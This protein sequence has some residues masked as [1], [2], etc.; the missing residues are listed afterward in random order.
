MSSAARFAFVFAVASFLS[1]P[2]MVIAAPAKPSFEWHVTHAFSMFDWLGLS[3]LQ[4]HRWTPQPA[5]A[6]HAIEN[7]YVQTMSPGSDTGFGKERLPKRGEPAANYESSPYGQFVLHLISSGEPKTWA[8]PPHRFPYHDGQYERAYAQPSSTNLTFKLSGFS[9]LCRLA[10]SDESGTYGGPCEK[11]AILI[12]VTLD[13]GKRFTHRRV[14]V[15]DDHGHSLTSEIQIEHLTIVGLGDSYAAG[16]GDP[17]APTEWS[18][19]YRTMRRQDL[20]NMFEKGTWKWIFQ[21]QKLD[22]ALVRRSAIWEDNQC[23]RSFWSHQ[24]MVAL[25]LASDSSHRLVTFLHYACTGA[26]VFDGL[27]VRQNVP[28]G[29]PANC[30]QSGHDEKCRVRR[31]QLAAAVTDL[32]Q[33]NPMSSSEPSVVPD[34]S[35]E[36]ASLQELLRMHGARPDLS[37]LESYELAKR[38]DGH[39]LDLV[40]CAG[41]LI[42]PDLVMLS[43]G[44]NDIGFGPLV[45]W[46]LIPASSY[47]HFG[48][49]FDRTWRFL[50]RDPN[51]YCPRV[52][53]STLD[54]KPCAKY[55][56]SYFGTLPLRLAVLKHAL[57][58]FMDVTPQSVVQPNYPD[59]FRRS[60]SARLKDPY[61]PDQAGFCQEKGMVINHGNGWDGLRGLVA[62]LS[63]STLDLRN[64]QINITPAE[65]GFAYSTL[66]RFR[67]TLRTAAEGAQ[68][69]S[70]FNFIDEA[71]DA[72]VGHGFCEHDDDANA[73]AGAPISLPSTP[74]SQRAPDWA[75]DTP[76][77]CAIRLDC[78]HPFVPMHRSVRTV[79]DSIRTQT[80][81][82]GDQLAGAFHPTAQGQAQIADLILPAARRVVETSTGD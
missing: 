5:K 23:N 67:D 53:G 73:M 66:E 24:N 34:Y 71:K 2:V 70:A 50:A 40:R 74:F 14:S 41:H 15:R 44:G 9:G 61:H 45:R 64:W 72:F 21:A 77:D 27:L 6:S 31:S 82:N 29:S 79:N 37:R 57:S 59:P 51:V 22:P 8:S 35:F 55:I 19:T 42:K 12:P 46:T 75:P 3:D 43:I 69:A 11:S 62:G 38:K 33:S 54:G 25:R 13:V 28:A 52:N 32:C 76:G 63:Q 47:R 81:G 39:G 58:E 1:T 4:E 68:Q 26:E 17:D 30:D 65:A 48:L 60:L 10:V 36:D 16:E 18:E 80:S 56:D 49:K 78:W 20:N 7:W